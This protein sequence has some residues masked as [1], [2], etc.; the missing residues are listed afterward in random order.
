MTQ[1]QETEQRRILTVAHGDY[2]KGLTAY[3]FFKVHDHA[4]GED[5]VQDTFLKTW[6][7]I[8]NGGKIEVMKAFLYHILNHLIVDQYRKHKTSSLDVLVEKGFEPGIDTTASLFNNLDG[9]AALLLIRKL[10][11]MYQRV[12]HL[13]YVHGHSLKEMSNSTGQSQNT[14]AVQVHRGL[15]KLRLLHNHS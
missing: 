7:Y 2:G 15:A 13:R 10:P 4:T 9:K 3:A 11:L 5:L 12:M 1:T 8:V 14:V 6:K